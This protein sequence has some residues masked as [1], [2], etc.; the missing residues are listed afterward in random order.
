M[1]VNI[2]YFKKAINKST[3]NLILFTNDKF[4]I[5][6]LKNSFSNSEFSYIHDLL[7]TSDLKKNILVFE[8]SSKKKNCS[9]INKKGS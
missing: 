3:S 1:T 9:Y 6:S 7:K 4:E 8:V 5:I 2:R